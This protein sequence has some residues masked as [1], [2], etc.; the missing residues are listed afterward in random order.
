MNGLCSSTLA[1]EWTNYCN[2]TF[3]VRFSCGG[4]E[5]HTDCWEKSKKLVHISILLIHYDDHINE[6]MKHVVVLVGTALLVVNWERKWKF[7]SGES[8]NKKVACVQGH[9]KFF[10]SLK[11]QF[12]V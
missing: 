2:K 6:Q 11:C 10:S 3:H 9:Y 1:S 12:K 7:F 8:G 4:D 5:A